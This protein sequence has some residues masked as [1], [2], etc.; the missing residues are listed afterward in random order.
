[1]FGG[2]GGARGGR[3]SKREIQLQ[4]IPVDLVEDVAPLAGG[5]APRVTALTAPAVF[6]GPID[7]VSFLAYTQ[8]VLAPTL[9][10]G[11]VVVLDNL[12]VHRSPAVRAAVETVGATLCFLSKYS[13]DL[14][15]I[16]CASRS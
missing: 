14:N 7:G 2:D 15:P 11:D 3:G 13:L 6:K 5:A 8:Q 12:S 4:R 10:P 1:M 9:C 16:E